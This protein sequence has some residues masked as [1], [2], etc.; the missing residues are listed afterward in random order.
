M[1][2]MQ[3]VV[4]ASPSDKGVHTFAAT[5]VGRHIFNWL[6]AF[7][8]RYDTWKEATKDS[9]KDERHL[10]LSGGTSMKPKPD[11]DR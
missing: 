6:R 8:I 3:G 2:E 7:R 10:T 9:V 5:R 4:V 11:S 1:G